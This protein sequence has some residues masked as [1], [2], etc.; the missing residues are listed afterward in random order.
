MGSE[1]HRQSIGAILIC[2]QTQ[3]SC[4][5]LSL[6]T[7]NK[8][9]NLPFYVKEFRQLANRVADCC[10]QYLHATVYYN[11]VYVMFISC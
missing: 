4:V 11:Y 10:I 6:S 2:I 8:N 1:V 7:A 5:P 9:P 3:R